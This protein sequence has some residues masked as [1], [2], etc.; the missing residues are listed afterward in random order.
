[1]GDFFYSGHAGLMLAVAIEFYKYK[2]YWLSF[3]VSLCNVYNCIILVVTRSHYSLDIVG[4]LV[5]SHYFYILAGYACQ[6]LEKVGVY[7]VT[8]MQKVEESTEE[9]IVKSHND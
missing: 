9:L 1:M 2:Y 8:K 6:A 7:E 5:F 3:F 4:G